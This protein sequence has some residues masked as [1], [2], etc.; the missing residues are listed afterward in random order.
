MRSLKD[1]PVTPIRI[2]ASS[3]MLRD[4]FR[5]LFISLGIDFR[6]LFLCHWSN[7]KPS[8]CITDFSEDYRI[9]SHASRGETSCARRANKILPLVDASS[10]RSL[11][12][13]TMVE[14]SGERSPLTDDLDVKLCEEYCV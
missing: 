4:L 6:I 1:L 14:S 9:I 5:S 8:Q 11:Q 10:T 13:A 3:R 12:V 7:P 2:E